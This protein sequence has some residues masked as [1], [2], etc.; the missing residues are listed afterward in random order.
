MERASSSRLSMLE[1][2][3][4]PLTSLESNL[5]AKMTPIDDGIYLIMFVMFMISVGSF[6]NGFIL[7]RRQ[8]SL[9]K[10]G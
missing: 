9:E 5:T 2:H 6:E 1:S 7:E 10:E 8:N 3:I 4:N